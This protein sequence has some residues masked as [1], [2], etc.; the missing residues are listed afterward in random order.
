M[1]WDFCGQSCWS[2][3]FQYVDVSA[4]PKVLSNTHWFMTT[5]AQ[6][7]AISFHSHAKDWRCISAIY[8]SVVQLQWQ[9]FCYNNLLSSA[10]LP[11]FMMTFWLVV[12]LFTLQ[13]FVST[14]CGGEDVAEALLMLWS[15]VRKWHHRWVGVRA[16]E[17][18]HLPHT[19]I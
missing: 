13:F 3:V 10:A 17:A 1:L 16:C 6:E 18:K 7:H 4:A 12:K 5:A 14:S 19:H 8:S 9:G 2:S 11:V 15:G